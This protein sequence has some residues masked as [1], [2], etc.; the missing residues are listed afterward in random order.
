[1]YPTQ[2]QM[3]SFDL[4]IAVTLRVPFGD[5]HVPG[6]GTARSLCLRGCMHM[7]KYQY[8]VRHLHQGVEL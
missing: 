5:F 3:V 1:M 2:G 6:I 8:S 4:S 7:V